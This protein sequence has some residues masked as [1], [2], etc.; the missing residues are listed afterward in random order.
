MLKAVKE[1]LP[2]AEHRNCTRHIYANLRVKHGSEA[3]RNAFY[4]A[5]MATYPEAFKTAM[6]DLEKAS[7][8]AYEK[9]QEFDP[10]V[11]S[12]AYFETHAKTDSTENNISEC[13]NSWILKTRYM[14][15]IDMLTEIHDMIM[16][17][18]HQKRDSMS[19]VDY[20]ILPRAKKILEGNVKASAECTVK[21]DGNKNFQVKW[22][23]IGFCVNLQEQTC[24]CRVWELTGLP[25]AHAICAIQRMRLNPY[26]Y[27]SHYFKKE[28]Y[29]RC[30]SHCLE[31]L[32]GSPFWE[33]VEG[34]DVLPPPIVKQVRGRPKKQRRREGWEGRDGTASRGNMAR[35]TR[36]GKIMHCSNCKKRGHNRTRCPDPVQAAPAKSARG[37]K[38]KVT[39][40]EQE[41]AAEMEMQG[42]EVETGEAELMEE[43][44]M[45]STPPASTPMRSHRLAQ[46]S[47][48]TMD[49]EI[50]N[51]SSA[52]FVSF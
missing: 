43:A 49:S 38:R 14:P 48:N 44:L 35:L 31:V 24:S 40:E 37:R 52:V 23:G 17:R 51:A 13:F 26:D 8:R 34:D 21:W 10:K 47:Q 19:A 39:D 45:N 25:C 16:E 50:G 36:Q 20:I 4:H 30:Y 42:K 46:G 15:L 28:T 2:Y 22:R 18:L 3:V 41:I 6:K 7:K 9:M 32:R 29:M 1:L 27:V 12:K 33:E 5:S 11:W